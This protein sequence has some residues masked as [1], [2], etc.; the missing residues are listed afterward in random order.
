MLV[1]LT[2]GCSS[3]TE[4]ETIGNIDLAYI[5]DRDVIRN[6]YLISDSHFD[7]PQM[8]SN[9]N[10]DE[11]S[12]V[13]SPDGTK[14]AIESTGA[15][16]SFVVTEIDILDIETMKS[17]TVVTDEGWVLDLDWSPDENQLL[18][19]SG[20][21]Y[22]NEFYFNIFVMDIN[23]LEKINLT[24][25]PSKETNPV[26]SPDGSKIAFV[27]FRNGYSEL[28]MMNADGTDQN[29][30][31]AISQLPSW[32]AKCKSIYGQ[33]STGGDR[34]FYRELPY[35]CMLDVAP[36]WSPDGLKIAFV[37]ARDGNK[38]IYIM[39]VDGTELKNLSNHPA[40]DDD[41]S[42]SPDGSKIVFTSNRDGDFYQIFIMNIDGS[43]VIQITSDYGNKFT[44]AWRP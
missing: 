39:N 10:R 29:S 1:C 2:I 32:I 12:V 44:P 3:K 26:W 16:N 11:K 30:I 19:S 34:E 28:F 36:A 41:P 5:S 8:I 38:E 14:L 23:E 42:W 35:G 33:N 21:V 18:F 9:T 15:R 27:S 31:S 13:W 24:N 37:S 4:L 43:D 25:R 17:S 20:K 6:V 7:N 40:D 22:E